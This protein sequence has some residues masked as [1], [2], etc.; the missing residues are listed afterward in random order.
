ME[1]RAIVEDVA[2]EI[3]VAALFGDERAP[4]F[5]REAVNQIAADTRR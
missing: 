3:E 1:P 2:K 5:G 4:V